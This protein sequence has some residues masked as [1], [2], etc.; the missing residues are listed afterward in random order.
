VFGQLSSETIAFPENKKYF[1]V[2]NIDYYVKTY[3]DYLQKA[4]NE[5]KE[6]TKT[7]LELIAWSVNVPWVIEDG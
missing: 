3:C 5:K 6:I 7:S 1:S 2:H 4:L